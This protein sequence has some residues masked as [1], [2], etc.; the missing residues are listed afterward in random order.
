MSRKVMVLLVVVMVAALLMASCKDQEKDD[1]KN[2][3]EALKSTI[4]GQAIEIANLRSSLWEAQASDS[5]KQGKIDRLVDVVKAVDGELAKAT[6]D[7]KKLEAEND[8][9]RISSDSLPLVEQELTNS[10]RENDSLSTVLLAVPYEKAALV[11]QLESQGAEMDSVVQCYAVRKH[12]DTRPWMSKVFSSG[13]WELPFPEP[14]ILQ[15]PRFLSNPD[16]AKDSPVKP[17]RRR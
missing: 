1:L 5:M 14:G 11:S 12:N 17:T 2:Q 15:I 6:A 13:K 7:R 3:N 4:G 16:P 10:E 9:L 8:S